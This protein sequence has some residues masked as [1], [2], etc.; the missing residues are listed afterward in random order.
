MWGVRTCMCL[1]V[2]VCVCLWWVWVVK[3]STSHDTGT[4]SRWGLA[5]NSNKKNVGVAAPQ[6]PL[7]LGARD[8][9]SLRHPDSPLLTHGPGETNE[10]LRGGHR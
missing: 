3:R 5:R 1:C 8:L 6:L 9:V 7:P 2:C 10:L 4:G